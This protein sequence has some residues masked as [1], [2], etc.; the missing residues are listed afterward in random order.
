MV[1]CQTCEIF[2]EVWTYLEPGNV[3]LK[4][5]SIMFEPVSLAKVRAGNGPENETGSDAV[6]ANVQHWTARKNAWRTFIVNRVV[7]VGTN[8]ACDREVRSSQIKARRWLRSTSHVIPS[9]LRSFPN[10]FSFSYGIRARKKRDL[11]CVRTG[12]PSKLAHSR[13]SIDNGR[14]SSS[15]LFRCLSVESTH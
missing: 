4:D 7:A 9:L 2:K 6:R 13:S 1:R 3:K 11:T 5:G 10:L 8:G 15:T 12:F 14:I